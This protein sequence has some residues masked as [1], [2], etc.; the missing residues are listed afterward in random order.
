MCALCCILK[1]D[2]SPCLKQAIK[3]S[4]FKK[5]VFYLIVASGGLL[6]RQTLKLFLRANE[7]AIR[8]DS[9]EMFMFLQFLYFF[10]LTHFFRNFF[11]FY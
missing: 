8:N 10:S 2:F 7:S 4:R 6:A 9:N 3:L 1:L 11:S 5:G